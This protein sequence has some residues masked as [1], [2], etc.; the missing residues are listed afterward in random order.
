VGIGDLVLLA[1][2]RPRSFPGQHGGRGPGADEDE[3]ILLLKFR[4][5]SIHSEVE[6]INLVKS[7][8]RATPNKRP[9]V[10]EILKDLFCDS[11]F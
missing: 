7:I 8:L 5:S 9:A 2:G 10:E 3:D 4:Y 11:K 6:D 1:A